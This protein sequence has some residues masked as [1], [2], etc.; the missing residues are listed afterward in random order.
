MAERRTTPPLRPPSPRNLTPLRLC[1]FGSAFEPPMDVTGSGGVWVGHAC[2]ARNPYGNGHRLSLLS[3]SLFFPP[4]VVLP[5]VPCFLVQ[6]GRR[7]LIPLP[8]SCQDFSRVSK[9]T[10]MSFSSFFFPSSFCS[11][12]LVRQPFLILF[13]SLFLRS[14]S[15]SPSLSPPQTGWRGVASSHP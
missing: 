15:L 5:K 11:I 4:S 10:F 9:V 13:L 3:L 2:P 1:A 14:P 7:E 12:S 8:A 6:P